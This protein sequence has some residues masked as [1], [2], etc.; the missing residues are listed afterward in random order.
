MWGVAE[1]APLSAL[2]GQMITT[3]WCVSA[4]Y[5]NCCCMTLA[6]FIERMSERIA[7]IGEASGCHKQG[8]EER[9]AMTASLMRELRYYNRLT[10]VVKT[11]NKTFEV[12]INTVPTVLS[13]IH[14]LH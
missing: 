1:L 4:C 13:S 2:L 11:V 12:S 3:M 10:C 7:K 14:S 5:F 6:H 8:K 9:K